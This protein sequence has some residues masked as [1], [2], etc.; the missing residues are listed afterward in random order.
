[1]GA[2]IAAET[3]WKVQDFSPGKEPKNIEE[4]MGQLNDVHRRLLMWKILF[5]I[6][7]A[8]LLKMSGLTPGA[9]EEQL[10]EATSE[11]QR[12]LMS[13]K[14]KEDGWSPIGEKP[15]LSSLRASEQERNE[16]IPLEAIRVSEED[17]LSFNEN[18]IATVSVPATKDSSPSATQESPVKGK[19]LSAP[20]TLEEVI[21]RRLP[22]NYQQ[23]AS[24]KLNLGPGNDRKIAKQ[25]SMKWDNYLR[26]N[27]DMITRLKLSLEKY[28]IRDDRLDTMRIAEKDRLNSDEEIIVTAPTKE[29]H[30]PSTK[31]EALLFFPPREREALLWHF[32]STLTPKEIADRMKISLNTLYTTLHYSKK[33]LAHMLGGHNLSAGKWD[34]TPERYTSLEEMIS[35]IELDGQALREN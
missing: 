31:E 6:N 9:F 20:A 27:K 12:R 35:N 32:Y 7:D 16:P 25:L 15:S 33:D 23:I 29:F 8:D 11:F 5:A 1:V 2:V 4:I 24:L 3:L 19:R 14:V 17:P 22:V 10:N 13:S 26:A 28:H 21:K 30:P 34:V 18:E